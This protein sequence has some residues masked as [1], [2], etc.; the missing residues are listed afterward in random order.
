MLAFVSDSEP[1][2]LADTYGSVQGPGEIR[3]PCCRA[4]NA[5]SKRQPAEQWRAK[6]INEAE[7]GRVSDSPG[8]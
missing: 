1:N 7:F 6:P 4:M 8:T 2:A 3:G 5:A